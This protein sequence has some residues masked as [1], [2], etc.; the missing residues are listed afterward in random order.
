MNRTFCPSNSPCP[1][2]VQGTYT[3]IPNKGPCE[4]R[5]HINI[6]DTFYVLKRRYKASDTK[7]TTAVNVESKRKLLDCRNSVLLCRHLLFHLKQS[8]LITI[9]YEFCQT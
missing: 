2:S 1:G 4:E 3:F 8:I 7:C 9:G 5:G 6:D